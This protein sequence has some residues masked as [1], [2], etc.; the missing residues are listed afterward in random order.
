MEKRFLEDCLAK[1][2]SLEAIG[3]E[4][5]K[6][7]STVG[8]WVKKHGLAPFGTGRYAPKGALCS[9]QLRAL[10]ASGA[11]AVEIGRELH[12][13]ASTVRYWLRR[14]GIEL[15][16]RCGPRRRTHGG[17]KTAVFECKRHGE[18]DFVLEGRGHYRC[19]RCRS[20]AVSKRRRVVKRRLVE[21]A[22]GAC[23]LCGYHR[24][25]GA[26][27][28]HHVDPRRKTFQIGQAGH[29]RSLERCRAEARKCVLL[30]ANCHAEV[31]AGFATLPVDLQPRLGDF[32]RARLDK[33][34]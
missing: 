11:T 21:E 18:T 30:C 28:F 15:A 4:V 22:G 7:P 29:C 26:L 12:R 31:E 33:F 20:A 19:K 34:P 5:G 9:E 13:S 1:G 6:H 24:W 27:Q 32:R 10:A 14:Y 16:N 8:H 3:R 2:M 17:A 25:I 23:A